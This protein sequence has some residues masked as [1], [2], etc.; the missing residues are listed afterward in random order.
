[1]G[2]RMYT[3]ALDVWSLGCVFAEM[4]S[5]SPLFTGMSQ[6]EQLFQIFSKLGT[7]TASSWPAFASHPY[8]SDCMFPDWDVS[9]SSELSLAPFFPNIPSSELDLLERC[10]RC[11]PEKRSTAAQLLAH[12][13]FLP[14][15]MKEQEVE[16]E[17]EEEE[18]VSMRLNITANQISTAVVVGSLRRRLCEAKVSLPVHK[19]KRYLEERTLHWEQVSSMQARELKSQSQDCHGSRNKAANR[20]S[21]YS[22]VV[23]Y[24]IDL[25]SQPASLCSDRSLH[26]AVNIFSRY[27]DRLVQQQHGEGSDLSCTNTQCESDEQKEKQ[28]NVVQKLPCLCL[29]MGASSCEHYPISSPTAQAE[30]VATTVVEVGD[31]KHASSVN[32]AAVSNPLLALGIS[33]FQLASKFEDVSFLDAAKVLQLSRQIAEEVQQ[34][35][36]QKR[37]GV[38][39]SPSPPNEI[40]VGI[41]IT[42]EC[43]ADHTMEEEELTEEGRLHAA[44]VQLCAADI[45]RS[46]QRVLQAL[47]FDIC[48][49]TVHSFLGYFSEECYRLLA[50]SLGP[51]QMRSTNDSGGVRY[52]SPF[53][54]LVVVQ[55][56]VVEE[57]PEDGGEHVASSALQ[58]AL[59]EDS[60]L[61]PYLPFLEELAGHLCWLTLFS[62]S[63]NERFAPSL[64]AAAIVM[65]S[66][67]L[68]M[69]LSPPPP[70]GGSGSGDGTV[71]AL[72]HPACDSSSQQHVLSA[73]QRAVFCWTGYSP[74]QLQEYQVAL[75]A[76]LGDSPCP[77][78]ATFSVPAYG[79][80]AGSLSLGG[81][82]SNVNSY[83]LKKAISG[84]HCTGS[85]GHF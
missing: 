78:T 24:L 58:S 11:C 85:E 53:P 77:S 82:I 31:R 54:V 52:S 71:D 50:M 33:C 7:P 34:Q 59:G 65:L 73:L 37:H 67:N 16:Q 72:S 48:S 13:A 70:D 43:P 76:A 39:N 60:M 75:C 66:V 81:I 63:L 5:G 41:A 51:S 38:Q 49:P 21:A 55:Q 74:N 12:S 28:H 14:Y 46:E 6:V 32:G 10:L 42:M 1:M 26:F 23:R 27:L 30:Y 15:Q 45:L 25:Q 83:T 56:Q 79:S 9:G 17:E 80:H 57:G 18:E 47:G 8:F 19:V 22:T 61:Y 64:Q 3:E 69:S 4:L 40:A 36:L 35:L 29:I 68:L 2:S 62:T 84:N 20:C 44:C